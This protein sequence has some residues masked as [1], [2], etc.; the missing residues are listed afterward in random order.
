M[1]SHAVIHVRPA[2]LRGETVERPLSDHKIWQ[3]YQRSFSEHSMISKARSSMISQWSFSERYG[4]H[5]LC[6]SSFPRVETRFNTHYQNAYAN[7]FRNA[8]LELLRLSSNS[9]ASTSREEGLVTAHL[10]CA[11]W[12]VEY[13]DHTPL[14]RSVAT[15]GDNIK[16]FQN[17]FAFIIST[18]TCFWL[19]R[20]SDRT[21]FG[22][23]ER[24]F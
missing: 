22:V 15:V 17:N 2:F 21:F 16:A 19:K 10:H 13:R 12:P 1:V 23:S 7:A 18:E 8:F 3:I 20:V 9:I 14:R 5:G 6:L 4:R 11:V 24:R